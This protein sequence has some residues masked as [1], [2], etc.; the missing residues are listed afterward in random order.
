M[1]NYMLKNLP[2]DYIFAGYAVRKS[3]SV[4]SSMI[5]GK[6]VF[7]VFTYVYLDN[8]LSMFLLMESGKYKS[9]EH[10]IEVEPYDGQAIM[11]KHLFR[12]EE[13]NQNDYELF[14]KEQIIGVYG[15][16]NM[17]ELMK[18]TDDFAME[19]G[20][21]D[22]KVQAMV[23]SKRSYTGMEVIG[24]INK[25]NRLNGWNKGM[26]TVPPITYGFDDSYKSVIG[27]ELDFFDLL[28][29]KSPD[30]IIR[31]LKKID[32]SVDGIGN[33]IEENEVL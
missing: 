22:M 10:N 12:G 32:D 28:S 31:E 27:D 9:V 16:R 14:D 3:T 11:S 4:I 23:D 8:Y 2:A 19:S 15:L 13:Y 24:V 1:F 17:E 30:K 25:F 5:D 29:N 20:L 21:N 26:I 33:L 18:I 7:D 6:L